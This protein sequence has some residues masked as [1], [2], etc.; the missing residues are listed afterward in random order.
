MIYLL[1]NIDPL[2]IRLVVLALGIIGLGLFLRKLKQ[3]YIVAYILAGVLLGNHGFEIITDDA[4]ISNLGA[5][6]LILLMFFIGM[7]VSIP[8]LLV[9]W[10]VSVFG[11]LIQVLLSLMFVSL[12]GYFLEWSLQEVVIFGFVLSI[13]STAVVLKLLEEKG[14]LHTK[15]GQKVLGV[16]LAQDILIVPMLII[17][18]I[19]SG[20]E[21]DAFEF[22][23]QI[24][25]GLILIIFVVW[26][27]RHRR[28][29]L[30]YH[31]TITKDHEIQVF[32]ALAICFG[33]SIITAY[34]GLSAA[35]G[36]FVAGMFISTA[37]S[38]EWVHESL[39]AFRVVFVALFFVSIGMLIDMKF[40]Q[41][42]F[43]LI[44]SLVAII[45]LINS[46]INT[47]IMRLF[48]E[49]WAN[50]LYAGATLAQIGEFS[51]ILGA[52]GY[53]YGLINLYDYQLVLSVIS[54]S[55]VMS[56]FWV[57]L[58]RNTYRYFPAS[59]ADVSE[60]EQASR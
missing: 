27:V 37:R 53:M 2:L 32:I 48:N 56:P 8:K 31:E 41:E 33:F 26:M 58:V 7:E 20:K 3:P 19:L 12:L 60:I 50:S 38:T 25:G 57:I 24:V 45:F 43:L 29:R 11:T 47:F 13:S 15:V 35:L 36:A 46:F 44:M 40:I 59:E 16:L 49:D 22:G 52:T 23:K 17:L 39:H 14:D 10:R 55:L 6:G 51:F 9:T 42:N 5:S 34:F 28:L 30:P 18:N 54:I 4:L 21:F 1:V